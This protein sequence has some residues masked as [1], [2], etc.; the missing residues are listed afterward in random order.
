M[1]VYVRSDFMREHG[2]Q[3]VEVGVLE[4]ARASSRSRRAG[5]T[6]RRETTTR[7]RLSP[8]RAQLPEDVRRLVRARTTSSTA[9][10]SVGTSSARTPSRAEAAQI[11]YR[12]FFCGGGERTEGPPAKRAT[13][14]GRPAPTPA[15]ADD[16][17]R[18]IETEALRLWICGAPAAAAA[19]RQA[20]GGRQAEPQ[21]GQ[22][23]RRGRREAGGEA[24]DEAGTTAAEERRARFAWRARRPDR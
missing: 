2:A 14:A 18:L 11:E 24:G 16:E 1:L 12:E 7:R 19:D 6:R 3:R 13:G 20:G 5:T 4:R 17:F 10:S 23:R 8:L 15:S 21:A 22:G 9:R